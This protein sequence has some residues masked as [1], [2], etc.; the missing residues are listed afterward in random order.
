M[1]KTLKISL[2]AFFACIAIAGLGAWYAAS[3]INPTQLTKLL[4]SSVKESTGRDLKI[5]GPVSLNLFP[6]ISVKAEQ[7]SLSNAS[8]ASNPNLLTLKEVELDIRLLPLLKGSVEISRI[9]L[10]GLEANLQTNSAGVGNWNLTPPVL[11]GDNSV[12]Q[13]AN[14]SS[15]SSDNA[16]I[17]FKTIDIVD[18]RIHYQDGTQA[19]K[20]VKVPKLSFSASDGKRLFKHLRQRQRK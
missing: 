9:G 15:S 10:S 12:T 6:S 2:I 7:V 18:A 4:S 19:T 5:T 17:S 20:T 1:N 8:W 13:S 14:A 3:F 16:L 11:A